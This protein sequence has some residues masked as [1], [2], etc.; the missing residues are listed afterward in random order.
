MYVNIDIN[1]NNIHWLKLLLIGCF[2]YLR[3]K[4]SHPQVQFST[5]SLCNGTTSASLLSLATRISNAAEIK[6]EIIEFPP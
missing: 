2:F 1:D 6:L 4:N 3:K 5:L